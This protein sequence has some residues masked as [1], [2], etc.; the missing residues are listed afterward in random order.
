MHSAARAYD[1]TA[2]QTL[3]PRDLEAQLLLKAANKLQSVKDDFEVRRPELG[4]ALVYNRKLWTIFVT[5]VTGPEHPLP[6]DVR[7]N[8]ANIGLFVLNRTIDIEIAPTPDKLSALIEINRN[9]AAGL[10]GG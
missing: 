7:E 2:T 3:K 8:V 10:R 4:H 6:K 9:I 5:A 1:R